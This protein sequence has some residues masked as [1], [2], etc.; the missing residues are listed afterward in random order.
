MDSSLSTVKSP[1]DCQTMMIRR[2]I[3]S[4]PEMY[5]KVIYTI[6]QM[7]ISLTARFV[8]RIDDR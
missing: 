3:H 7:N 5:T 6:E 8:F 1:S 4:T 2:S